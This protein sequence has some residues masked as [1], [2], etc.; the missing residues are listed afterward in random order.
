LDATARNAAASSDPVTGTG[1]ATI[2]AVDKSCLPALLMAISLAAC[3]SSGAPQP[4]VL[5]PT[6]AGI[7]PDNGSTAGGTAVTITGTHFS[8][9]MAVSLGGSPATNVVVASDS[10]ASALT[11]PH[12]TGTVDVTVAV[13]SQSGTVLPADRSV[14]NNSRSRRSPQQD[15]AAHLAGPVDGRG[16]LAFANQVG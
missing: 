16:F 11:G 9:G 13:G 6:V 3:G 2:L 12:A 1:S 5:P 10:M 4:S 15:L 8:S 14:G 7:A